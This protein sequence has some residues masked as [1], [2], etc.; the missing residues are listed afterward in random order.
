MNEFCF[1][2]YGV[3]I[4]VM[5]FELSEIDTAKEIVGKSEFDIE[6]FNWSENDLPFFERK[7]NEY[8][9]YGIVPEK[10]ILEG[11]EDYPKFNINNCKKNIVTNYPNRNT[12]TFN[13]IKF[14]LELQTSS[15][16][17]ELDDVLKEDDFEL[18]LTEIDLK[19]I[20]YPNKIYVLNDINYK[21]N[22]IELQQRCWWIER[23]DMYI[24][25]LNNN[26]QLINLISD[27]KFMK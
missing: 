11:I 12:K 16:R 5:E 7:I 26:N 14:S 24:Q 19:T 17:I 8:N 6:K 4:D 25:Y 13:W 3:R 21:K 23:I 20:Q 18:N 22:K 15:F 10:A 1:D 27:N 9:F 2:G